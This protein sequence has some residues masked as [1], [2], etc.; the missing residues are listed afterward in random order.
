M[1]WQLR[2]ALKARQQA[3][4]E[5]L[6]ER[7]VESVE[8]LLQLAENKESAEDLKAWAAADLRFQHLDA[9]RLANAIISL[10]RAKAAA[11]RTL[12][13]AVPSGT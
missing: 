2:S 1:R 4:I 12:S 7:T 10:R 13:G 3:I 8:D 11:L 9:T 6:K 5:H